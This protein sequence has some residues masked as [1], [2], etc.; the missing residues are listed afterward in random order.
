MT[1]QTIPVLL[2]SV[3]VAGCLVIQSLRRWADEV[4]LG[5]TCIFAAVV[6][7]LLTELL[8]GHMP[9][10][11]AAAPAMAAPSTRLPYKLTRFNENGP[12]QM[13][14]ANQAPKWR[15]VGQGD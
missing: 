14:A 5:L 4:L 11:Y 3:F 7:L 8:A 2:A 10:Q 9:R 15:F 12:T 13:R 6:A 1:A